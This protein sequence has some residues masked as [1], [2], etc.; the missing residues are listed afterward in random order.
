MRQDWLPA[1]AEPP[2][3][4]LDWDLWLGPAPWRPYNRGYLD[5][6]MAWLNFYDFGTGVAG[7]CSH[8]LCQCQGAIGA[9]LTSAVDYEYPG[10]TTAEGLAARYANG[11]NLVLSCGGWRGSC[12]VRYEGTDGWVSMADGYSAP[13]LSSPSL[14]AERKKLVQDYMDRHQRPMNHWRDFLNCVKTRRQTVAHPEVA[15]RSM[16]TC[17]V[18]NI[19]MLL[20]RNVKWDPVREEFVNDP[21][22]NRLRSRAVREPWQS[23]I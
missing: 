14:L 6:C 21:E 5:G 4:E 11:V 13:D 1:Q 8:T 2:K 10:N 3:E 22:A 17:H 19:C 20:K 7:W 9:D 18:A 12:G 23:V 16:S 15:H